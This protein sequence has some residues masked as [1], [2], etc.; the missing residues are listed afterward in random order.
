MVVATATPTSLSAPTPLIRWL[1]L[2]GAAANRPASAELIARG[3]VSIN[4]EAC[5]EPAHLVQSDDAVAVAGQTVAP[6]SEHVYL[7]LHK[8]AG[9]LT[10]RRAVRQLQGGGVAADE[11]PTVYDF[12]D[13]ATRAR[14]CE[15]VGR[16]DVDT[17][18]LLLFTSDG[19]LANRLLEPSCKVGKVYVAT[20]RGGEPLSA[21]AIA[22]LASGVE[23]TPKK[24]KPAKLVRG[25]AVNEPGQRGVVQMAVTGGAFHQVKYMFALVGRPL[26]QLHRAAFAG[27]ELPSADS[28]PVGGWRPLSAA[29]VAT[30]CAAAGASLDEG[31]G[32]LGSSEAEFV[33]GHRCT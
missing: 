27:V 5:C 7:M 17:T 24:G 22:Q 18:G 10:A 8:P 15:A 14:H 32:V 2:H 33:T 30:L 11:R 3:V 23:L 19:L 16:L 31:R 26:A 12:L 28:L 4:G 9:C 25:D 6:C 21:D 20:L 29:E 13:A 1:T